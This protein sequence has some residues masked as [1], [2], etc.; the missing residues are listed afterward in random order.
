MFQS[1]RGA[2]IITGKGGNS[3]GGT[4]G[5]GGDIGSGNS[6]VKSQDFRASDLS[7]FLFPPTVNFDAISWLGTGSGGSGFTGGRGG[8]IGS[9][10]IGIEL[11][12]DFRD[13]ELASGFGGSGTGTQANGGRGGD[14]GSRNR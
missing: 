7:Q 9:G 1:F 2:K 12:Q 13:A 3:V 6:T 14:I 11:K 4:G 8:D 10:N 5:R